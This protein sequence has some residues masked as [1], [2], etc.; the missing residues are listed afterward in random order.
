MKF[1]KNKIIWILFVFVAATLFFSISLSTSTSAGSDNQNS[2]KQHYIFG[3]VLRRVEEDHVKAATNNIFKMIQGMHYKTTGVV[4]DLVTGK[5]Y[6]SI[7]PAES[8]KNRQYEV[9]K[10]ILPDIIKIGTLE[11]KNQNPT[12]VSK[13]KDKPSDRYNVLQGLGNL[14]NYMQ[15]KSENEII[16]FS[17]MRQQ[18]EKID[19]Q[20][21]GCP[22]D[23]YLYAPN[24]P[25][26]SF[27]RLYNKG[28]NAHVKIITDSTYNNKME[29]SNSMARF[30]HY[31]LEAIGSSLIYWGNDANIEELLSL[32]IAKK[33]YSLGIPLNKNDFLAIVRDK[34][35]T[36]I[37]TLLKLTWQQP[38]DLDLVVRFKNGDVL[39]P[40][41]QLASIFINDVQMKHSRSNNKR[42]EQ[43]SGLFKSTDIAEIKV[44]WANPYTIRQR[45]IY[46][47]VVYDS[48]TG[49][50]ITKHF[51]LK[52]PKKSVIINL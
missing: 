25:F 15:E 24:S 23:A 51:A 13:I 1:K 49:K 40:H 11:Y 22:S 50:V 37:A 44:V 29:H 17:N 43:I 27:I 41:N 14:F 20:N 32:K 21:Y 46:G 26:A 19:F 34:S 28:I 52:K 18:G 31:L 35:K 8:E 45:K 47:S 12:P 5:K 36:F 3:I 7:P 42:T 16:L 4:L 48:G 9:K 2:N 38:C 10:T 39:S 6:F 30:Y 33:N